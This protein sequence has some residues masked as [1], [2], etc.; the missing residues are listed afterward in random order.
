MHRL[1]LVLVL[2][3]CFHAI[4]ASCDHL[5][6]RQIHVTIMDADNTFE[7]GR[8][9]LF[10]VRVQK[11]DES[12][13]KRS[14]FELTSCDFTFD[15]CYFTLR[16][17]NP[18][19]RHIWLE[20]LDNN[21]VVLARS[22]NLSGIN[23]N[24]MEIKANLYLPCTEQAECDANEKSGNGCSP[25]LCSLERCEPLDRE[26]N[27]SACTI[28][29][30]IAGHC[31]DGACTLATCGDGLVCTA[32]NCTTGPDEGPE[33]CDQGLENSNL[34]GGCRNKDFLTP[35]ANF[36]CG[37]GVRDSG[38]ECDDSNSNDHDGCRQDCTPSVSECGNGILEY[39]EEC[40][41]E[42]TTTEKC[43]NVGESCMVCNAQCEEV[44]GEW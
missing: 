21:G 27:G 15:D 3:F 17:D 33:E 43:P 4:L 8:H 26:V 25:Y 1:F 35:C 36:R 5:E 37:D 19:Q 24:E 10:V 20:A 6:P 12:S 41:D 16:V 29:T 23:R 39:G 30:D 31:L 11:T 32:P 34:S 14:Q 42:N 38:E 2:S 44:P 9:A 13:E 40:D 28:G 22:Y 7:D 18:G